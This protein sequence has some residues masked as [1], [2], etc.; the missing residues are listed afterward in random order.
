M[1][2]YGRDFYRDRHQK[3]A[4]SANTVLSKVLNALPEVHSVVDV[5]CGVGTWLSVLKNN[6]VREI[7][8]IDGPW[9]E[10]DLLKIPEQ[11]FRQAD[12]RKAIKSDRKYDLAIS[13]EVAEHLPPEAAKTFV[14]SL[15]NL[16]D[17]V[18]FSAAIPFQGGTNHINEQWPDYWAA[19]F[20]ENGYAVLDFIR[21]EIW[22][23]SSI[24]IWYRQ[25]TLLFIKRER[26][27]DLRIPNVDTVRQFSSLSVVHPDMYLAK[28]RPMTSLMGSCQLFWR[29]LR[30]SIKQILRGT[31][32]TALY[33][34]AIRLRSR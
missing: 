32:N 20:N 23:D 21:R 19:L 30:K 9:V 12:L 17:F 24:P 3:T 34:T 14:E 2:S 18:L 4:Y 5:G 8:G 16:S 10:K 11:A 29:S 28:V 27:K 22:T 1:K 7:Q 33:R 25:N 26:M 6:G 13:L 31:A 15:V